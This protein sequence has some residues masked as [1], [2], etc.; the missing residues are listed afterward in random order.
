MTQAKPVPAPPVLPDEQIKHMR[1][2]ETGAQFEVRRRSDGFIVSDKQTD[3]HFLLPAEA[4]SVT[5][6][7]K[8]RT[9]KFKN[10]G[11]PLPKSAQ[12]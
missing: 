5:D 7:V 8:E 2:R 11:K 6:F 1:D 9:A 4:R 3:E 10:S 12:H